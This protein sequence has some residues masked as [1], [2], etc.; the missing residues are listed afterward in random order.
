MRLPSDGSTASA[1]LSPVPLA[2]RD[3]RVMRTGEGTAHL[4]TMYPEGS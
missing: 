1:G 4:V 3:A 2:G